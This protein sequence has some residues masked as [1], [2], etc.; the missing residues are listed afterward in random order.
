MPTIPLLTI[1]DVKRIYLEHNPTGH[2]FDR[3]TMRFFNQTLRDFH[4]SRADPADHDH[5][6]STTDHPCYIISA[7]SRS[8]DGK[9]MGITRRIFDATTGELHP[10]KE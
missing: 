2:F 6:P 5:L 7:A 9:L 10:S 1:Y 8:R 3:P 4:V